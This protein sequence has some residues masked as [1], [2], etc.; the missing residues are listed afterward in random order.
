MVE[1]TCTVSFCGTLS[2]FS[3]S[4]FLIKNLRKSRFELFKTIQDFSGLATFGLVSSKNFLEK[5]LVNQEIGN[6]TSVL[7]PINPKKARTVDLLFK[8]PRLPFEG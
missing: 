5:R 6:P 2:I 3:E 4:F 7:F 8:R 1:T